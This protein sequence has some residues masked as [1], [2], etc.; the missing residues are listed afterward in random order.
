MVWLSSHFALASFASAAAI[1]ALTWATSS[2]SPSVVLVPNFSRACA[3]VAFDGGKL[4]LEILHFRLALFVVELV[5]GACVGKFLELLQAE[6]GQFQLRLK[7]FL[8]TS[9][10][11][12]LL[13]QIARARSGREQLNPELSQLRLEVS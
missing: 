13:L 8:L 1:W 5:A 9:C 7:G 6:T 11:F 3:S 4:A 10:A 2:C 12:Q